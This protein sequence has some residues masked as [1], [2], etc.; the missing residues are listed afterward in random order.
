MSCRSIKLLN[1]KNHEVNEQFEFDF[2]TKKKQRFKLNGIIVR[3][4]YI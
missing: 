1:L 3:L 4:L 2:H